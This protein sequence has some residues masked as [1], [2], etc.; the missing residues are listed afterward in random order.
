MLGYYNDPENTAETIIDGWLHTGD[1]GYM[2]EDGYLYITGRK[3]NVIITKTGKNIFPE[4]IEYYLLLE[5]D[6][7]ETI[8]YGKEN[9]IEG[10]LLC[11]AIIQPDFKSLEAKGI[12]EDEDIY[13]R[14]REIVDE[15]NAKV[16]LYK[17]IRRIEVR[18]ND[19][20]KTTLSLIH[21]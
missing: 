4:E 6:I 8:V 11:T 9:M 10:D 19:F 12:T 17:K 16:P 7:A 14:I 20:I 15:V 21:I 5:D 1:Y 18:E 3:K 2:D 13:R